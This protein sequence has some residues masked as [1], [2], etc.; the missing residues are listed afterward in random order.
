MPEATIQPLE[1]FRDWGAYCPRR[2]DQTGQR[3]SNLTGAVSNFELPLFHLW[4]QEIA[5]NEDGVPIPSIFYCERCL[6]Q[7]TLVRDG[8]AVRAITRY[9]GDQEEID[10]WVEFNR[11]LTELQAEAFNEGS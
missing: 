7:M 9:Y 10:A 5:F 3:Q 11:Q 6:A 4:K 1:A 2:F 8:Q